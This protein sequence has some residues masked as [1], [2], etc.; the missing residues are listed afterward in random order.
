MLHAPELRTAVPC[1]PA[2]AL[3]RERLSDVPN[4]AVSMKRGVLLKRFRAPVN[5]SGVGIRQV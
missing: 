3:V 4:L 5:G 2:F 1:D